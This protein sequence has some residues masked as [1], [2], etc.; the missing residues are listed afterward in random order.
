MSTTTDPK[1]PRLVSGIDSGPRPQNEAYL[2][3][4]VD[5]RVKGFVRPLRFA[6]KHVG[7]QAPKYPLSDLADEQKTDLGRYDYVKF[8]KYPESE[9]PVTGRYWT[10]SQLDSIHKGCNAVTTVS[11]EIAETYARDPFFYGATYCA[12]CQMHRPVAEF[13]WIDDDTVVGS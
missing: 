13:V 9:S 3:L 2:V 4:S 11:L 12:Q 10:Q 7:L 6:Y 8:E 1:D 5:E